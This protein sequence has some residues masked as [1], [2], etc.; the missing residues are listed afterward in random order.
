MHSELRDLADDDDKQQQQQQQAQQTS[1]GVGI[2]V[3]RLLKGKKL[4]RVKRVAAPKG[5][6]SASTG[7]TTEQEITAGADGRKVMRIKVK[8]K[9]KPPSTA[10]S[11]SDADSMAPA[12]AP[13]RGRRGRSDGASVGTGVLSKAKS[14]FT[15]GGMK[16]GSGGK[17]FIIDDE[18]EE[19]EEEDFDRLTQAHT[20]EDYD[21][22]DEYT[23]DVRTNNQED[24]TTQKEELSQA[25]QP[26][27]MTAT[28]PSTTVMTSSSA[29]HQQQQQQQQQEHTASSP[30]QRKGALRNS[31]AS[32]ASPRSTAKPKVT[33]KS[34]T[35][36]KSYATVRSRRT[37]GSKGGSARQMPAQ[38]II[39]QPNPPKKQPLT[40]VALRRL[41]I[42]EQ[43][44]SKG[45][46]Y[47]PNEFLVSMTKAAAAANDDDAETQDVSEISYED[48]M[49][50]I[51]G[52]DAPEDQEVPF[53]TDTCRQY[54]ASPIFGPQHGR[55]AEAL[56][57]QGVAQL[58]AR[59]TSEAIESILEAVGLLQEKHGENS[60]A[61][62]R[63]LH[64]LGSAFFLEGQLATAVEA[65]RK[66]FDVRK[67]VL[68]PYHTDTV[69]TF[70]NL[71]MVYLK[72][73]KLLEAARIFQEVLKIR[74][75]IYDDYHP[76]VAFP[77]RSLGCVYAKRKDKERARKTYWH[78]LRCF[79]QHG[80][81]TERTDTEAEMR[82]FGI[83]PPPPEEDDDDARLEI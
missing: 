38:E 75:A 74:K 16:L 63:G 5:T 14:W 21:D 39:C 40:G 25:A 65:T 24:A 70:S 76:S 58:N 26:A 59:Q 22:Y 27:T 7:E 33:P 77:A 17:D 78:A 44:L 68:G 52:P 67:Q 53:W 8:R 28:T 80:M 41:Q 55:T 37:V 47:K 71:A 46:N 72:M 45:C 51:M 69:D 15:F 11:T 9:P 19:D 35:T 56:L 81:V 12:A 50:L 18:E 32:M 60:L 36:P 62:A 13:R 3:K 43:W 54:K 64:L 82:R 29:S 48:P 34:P 6:A 4:V 79:E 10:T 61:A 57:N 20:N 73:N 2:G 49:V 1:G 23:M 31:A 42:Q 83:E 30:V 66:A